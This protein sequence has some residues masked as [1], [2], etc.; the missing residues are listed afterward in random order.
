MT[1][2]NEELAALLERLK[3]GISNLHY[4]DAEDAFTIITQLRTLIEQMREALQMH[5]DDIASYEEYEGTPLGKA[6]EAALTA[7]DAWL[8]ANP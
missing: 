5:Q 4:G 2:T 1:P 7:A 8:K 3:G 6:T